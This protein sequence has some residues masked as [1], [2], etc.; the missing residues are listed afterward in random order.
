MD[1]T[2][3]INL[4]GTL[5]QIDEEAFK[6]LRDYLQAIDQKFR[7]TPGGNETIEDIE[8]RIAEIFLSQKGM[9]GVISIDN[10]N[11]M[12]S[13]IGKPEDFD[14]PGAQTETQR[15]SYGHPGSRKK[16]FRN[17]ENKI[18]GGVCGGIG[19]YVNTD[20][21]W[22]RILFVIF[23]FFFGFGF[24]VYL[25]LWIAMPSAES[26]SQKREMYG[27]S[28]NLAK[29]DELNNNQTSKVGNAFDAIF[30]ALGKVLFI[31]VRI[32]LIALGVCFVLTGFLALLTFIMVF[33]FKYPGSFSTD[34]VGFNIAYLPDFLNYIISPAIVPWVKALIA[35]V[36][37]IPLLA[38][39]YGGIRM[40]F[41]FR[42]RDG[43]IWLIALVL[44]VM[45]SAA[46][47]ILLF[48]EGIGFAENEQTVSQEYFKTSPDTLYI[49]SGR[50]ISDLN[51]DKEIDIPDE[52]YNIF[53]SEEKKQMYIRTNLHINV[54]EDKSAGVTIRKHSAGRSKFD[55]IENA[56]RLQ[57][58]LKI[59]GDTLLLD[60]FFTIPSD[61]KWSFD[62][63]DITVY[64][65]EN[66]VIHMDRTTETF[67]HSLYDDDFVADPKKS[68]WLMTEH[69]LD[70]IGHQNK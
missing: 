1:K 62:Y 6:I 29:P 63:V 35:L 70:Y 67:F 65:P 56:E 14:Q 68:F 16:L 60:E 34:A 48:N 61:S 28:H 17:P 27:S 66:T 43:Y 31:I 41:W 3:N 23:T 4:G 11:Y 46:L 22:I 7:N 39:I 18:I 9:A 69:G 44:W 58:N 47:S 45:S 15:P 49:K 32:L 54:T 24:F 37:S 51:T 40:I 25:A 21:V 53:I 38:L 42:V 5:F 52:N 19:A 57:Y 55:A 33:V 50:K 2:I 26:E 12:I 64:V 20:P 10:I 8:S 59:S 30:R 13:I 36:V